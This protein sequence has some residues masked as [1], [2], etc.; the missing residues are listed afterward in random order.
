MAE[1]D[2]HELL[3]SITSF[4]EK[5]AIPSRLYPLIFNEEEGHLKQHEKKA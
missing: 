3:V 1:T 5:N 4:L 2:Q